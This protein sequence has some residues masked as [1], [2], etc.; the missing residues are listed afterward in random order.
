MVTYDRE[1]GPGGRTAVYGMTA[2][3]TAAIRVTGENIAD[4]LVAPAS[5]G[6]FLAVFEGLHS[7]SGDEGSKVVV[8]RIGADGRLKSSAR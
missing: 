2:R 6:T 4:T 3:N 5:D 1:A 8:A 7:L